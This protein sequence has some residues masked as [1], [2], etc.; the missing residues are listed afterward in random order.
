MAVVTQ[1]YLKSEIGR[2]GRL[3]GQLELAYI[4]AKGL[5]NYDLREMV[6]TSLD[7]AIRALRESRK[8]M[9]DLLETELTL[10]AR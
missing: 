4:Q 2:A 5:A 3:I 1:S 9:E 6:T 10:R 8:E 7:D